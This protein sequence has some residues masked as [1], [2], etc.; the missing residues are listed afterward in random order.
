MPYYA[1]RHVVKPGITGWAA[2]NQNTPTRSKPLQK[3]QYDLYIKN[4]SLLLDISL[5][6]RTVNVVVRMM[7][8]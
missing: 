8:Q 6:L 4:R 2:I 3:L 5:L 1:L 7:G